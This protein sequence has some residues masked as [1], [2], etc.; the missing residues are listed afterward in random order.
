MQVFLI[1]KASSMNAYKLF[2]E[3]SVL[4]KCLAKFQDP[5]R[6]HLDLSSCYKNSSKLQNVT[7]LV[8]LLI[9]ALDECQPH[10]N[11]HHFNSTNKTRLSVKE[12]R[13]ILTRKPWSR[14]QEGCPLSLDII[15][16]AVWQQARNPCI[17]QHVEKINCT[18]LSD[19]QE[20]L[21]G[22]HELRHHKNILC[23]ANHPLGEDLPQSAPQGNSTAIIIY[24]LLTENDG[25]NS[26]QK[27]EVANG[28]LQEL[29]GSEVEVVAHRELQL[30]I[31]GCMRLKLHEAALF[32]K[33]SSSLPQESRP[34][35]SSTSDKRHP[36]TRL[37]STAGPPNSGQK[38]C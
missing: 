11:D 7:L 14:V 3:S 27:A 4:L 30:F 38:Q 35:S 6:V 36:Q 22:D 2:D 26:V 28:S 31:L 33:A 19:S 21:R 5:D 16:D 37:I 18:R 24:Q 34:L 23:Y 32:Y 8:T 9:D 17:C 10:Y 12:L 29:D 1:D 15:G 20:G 25:S 13:E